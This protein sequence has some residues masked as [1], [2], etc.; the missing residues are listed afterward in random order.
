MKPKQEDALVAAILKVK[1][2]A[3][4]PKTAKRSAKKKIRKRTG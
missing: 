3:D 2:A 1:P 4:M